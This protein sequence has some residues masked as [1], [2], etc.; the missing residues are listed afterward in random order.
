LIASQKTADYNVAVINDF[1]TRGHILRYPL[2]YTYNSVPLEIED[3][4]RAKTL[5]VLAGRDYNFKDTGCLG[6]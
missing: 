6:D 4:P 1:D 3:Y 5:Y 2:E